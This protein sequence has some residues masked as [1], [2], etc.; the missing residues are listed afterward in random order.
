MIRIVSLFSLFIFSFEGFAQ[1]PATDE[2]QIEDLI[3]NAFDGV[4]SD[5]DE[6]AVD[7]YHTPDFLLLE[8]GEVWTNDI[9]KGYQVKG[10]SNSQGMKRV[11]TFEFIKVEVSENTA[12]CAYKNFAAISK[13]DEIVK[14]LEWLESANAIK[15]P[16][17]WKLTLM[18]STRVNR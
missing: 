14:K 6:K 4:W 5:L 9:I 8:H 18:H 12:W 13:D 11:N 17:G 16:T 3:Q 10:K 1:R 15:T 7:K 2:Q